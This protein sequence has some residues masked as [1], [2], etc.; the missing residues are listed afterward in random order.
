MVPKNLYALLLMLAMQ[1]RD[2]S[3]RVLFEILKFVAMEIYNFNM[4]RYI[5]LPPQLIAGCRTH[6][7]L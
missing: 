4:P 5:F 6:N 1:A 2:F 7:F 3:L